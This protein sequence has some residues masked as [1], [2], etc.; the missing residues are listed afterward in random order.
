MRKLYTPRVLAGRGGLAKGSPPRGAPHVAHKHAAGIW[1]P[2]SQESLR[3]LPGPARVFTLC[4]PS[5]RI[6]LFLEPGRVASLNTFYTLLG[7][8]VKIV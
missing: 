1:S 6:R 7:P 5:A 2:C 4:F 3:P 8:F